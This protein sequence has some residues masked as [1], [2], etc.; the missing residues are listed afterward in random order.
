MYNCK[1][2]MAELKK[3]H[4]DEKGV[5]WYVCPRCPERGGSNFYQAF[6]G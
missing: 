6:G 5:Q 3:D 2:C 4:V 1:A